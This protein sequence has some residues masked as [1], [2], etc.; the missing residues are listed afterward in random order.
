MGPKATMSGLSQNPNSNSTTLA[1]PK[2]CDD[3]SNWADYQLWICK[4]MGAKGLWRH[5]E[6]TA[7]APVPYV[8]TGGVAMLPDGKTPAMEEQIETK[9]S[10]II[11]FEKQEYLAQHIILSTTSTWLGAKIKDMLTA[12]EM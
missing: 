12:K 3:G 1:V 11:E 8:V 4:A 7:T 10:K 2:L 6:G 5:V 9:E